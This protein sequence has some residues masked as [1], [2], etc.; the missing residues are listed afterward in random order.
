MEAGQDYSVA[1]HL[2]DAVI[3]FLPGEFPHTEL[4]EDNVCP[5]LRFDVMADGRLESFL[6]A[7]RCF[8][9]NRSTEG[10]VVAFS[11]GFFV[12][13]INRR[14]SEKAKANVHSLLVH[15]LQEQANCI[16]GDTLMRLAAL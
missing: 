7:G 5:H 14:E 11:R 9:D 13:G 3:Y 1:Q 12:N 16:D 4:G 2:A 10:F 6:E 8:D 15:R